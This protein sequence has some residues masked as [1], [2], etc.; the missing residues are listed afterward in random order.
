M[1]VLNSPTG[2][3]LYGNSEFCHSD[4]VRLESI[5]TMSREFER[6]TADRH[7]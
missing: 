4:K 6:T 7:V 1:T 5:C 2:I 3:T